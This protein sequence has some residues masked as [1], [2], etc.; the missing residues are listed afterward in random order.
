MKLSSLR[1]KRGNIAPCKNGP[2]R[3]AAAGGEE[4]IC[5]T[6]MT[7]FKSA[8][9]GFSHRKSMGIA[10]HWK[11]RDGDGGIIFYCNGNHINDPLP[12]KGRVQWLPLQWI[13]PWNQKLLDC[14]LLDEWCE[15]SRTSCHH[16]QLP[17]CWSF[18]KDLE[19]EHEVGQPSVLTDWPGDAHLTASGPWNAFLE[20]LS[21][22]TRPGLE[23]AGAHFRCCY[24][25]TRSFTWCQNQTKKSAVLSEFWLQFWGSAQ[26]P[27]SL[28]LNPQH[29]ARTSGDSFCSHEKSCFHLHFPL[30]NL[31]GGGFV[32]KKTQQTTPQIEWQIPRSE[33]TT[34]I[35]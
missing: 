24:R 13:W 10:W 11:C 1:D 12:T 20:K 3:E 31:G 5:M 16:L 22:E 28:I 15:T 30:K 27:D 18:D 7:T 23:G 8:A 25:R 35:S 14:K 17:G 9:W 34:V 32:K 26:P 29:R 21:R 33:G 2:C 4:G 6:V 19:P